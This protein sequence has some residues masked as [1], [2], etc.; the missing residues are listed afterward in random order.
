MVFHVI[1][2]IIN[3]QSNLQVWVPVVI[4]NSFWILLD[5]QFWQYFPIYI[6]SN[7]MMSKVRGR[8]IPFR[9]S[10]DNVCKVLPCPPSMP[11]FYT[12]I[13]L[14]Y[15]YPHFVL[16]GVYIFLSWYYGVGYQHTYC[17]VEYV[18]RRLYNVLK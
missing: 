3:E 5:V 6:P 11:L 2:E 18:C 4:I 15:K 16:M 8:R 17:L 13:I 9:P 12:V 1:A 10:S 7:T 14:L